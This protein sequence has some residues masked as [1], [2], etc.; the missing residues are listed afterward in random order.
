MR[1]SKY[2]IIGSSHAAIEALRAIRAADEEGQITILTKDRYLPYSPT[3]LPYVVS[4]R[5]DP[6]RV[7]IKDAAFLEEQNCE[8]VKEAEVVKLNPQR[9]LVRLKNGEEWGY[10]KLLIASGAS[11]VVP[12]LKGLGFVHYHVLR[13]LDDAIGLKK[14]TQKA[15]NA[16]VLGGGLVGM[17]AAEN[18]IKC[19]LKVTLVERAD[20][21][22]PG[23]FTQEAAKM[24]EDTFN[25]KGVD[26]RMGR[27]LIELTPHNVV[28]DDGSRIDCDLLLL[29]AGVKPNIGFIEGTGIAARQ[30]ILVDDHMR[31]NIS[32]IW[33]AGDVAEAKGIITGETMLNGILPDA[34]EQGRTAGQDMTDDEGLK[35]YLGGLPIN[36]YGFFGQQAISVGVIDSPGAEI[37][38]T[39]SLGKY[40]RIVLKDGR[41]KGISGVNQMIDAGIMWQLIMRGDDLTSVKEIFFYNPLETGRS[42]MSAGWR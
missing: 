31:T 23:Y 26:M 25:A 20:Q 42:L 12:P 37:H 38:E 40:M 21:V 7:F 27:M 10:E 11:P 5:S 36:T 24:I 35:P 2:L 13:S 3:I 39:K 17:H 9:S 33:A 14:A 32:N 34:V 22:L 4:G 8:Y 30:G 28:L 18:M 15:R 16:V 41:L 6:D 1:T 29:A 19:G